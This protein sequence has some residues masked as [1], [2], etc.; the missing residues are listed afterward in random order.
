[1]PL[2]SLYSKNEHDWRKATVDQIKNLFKQ[3]AC[4][5]ATEYR[6]VSVPIHITKQTL[7]MHCAVEANASLEIIRFLHQIDPKAVKTKRYDGC[8]PIHIAARR[9]FFFF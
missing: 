6:G 3:E 5:P 1:M 4:L 9:S 2:L 8:L 7:P